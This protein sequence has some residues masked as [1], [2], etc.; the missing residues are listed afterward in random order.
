MNRTPPHI[1]TSAQN[2]VGVLFE[3]DFNQLHDV[4]V[5]EAI[6]AHS[7]IEDAPI[8]S[9]SA[10][11]YARFTALREQ[12]VSL[13]VKA[14]RAYFKLALANPSQTENDPDTWAQIQLRT[15]VF[16][17]F[18]WIHDWYIL[19]CEGES[20]SVPRV[21]SLP[22]IP[23]QT[24]SSAIPT[25]VSPLPS[26]NSWRA[27]CWLFNISLALFGIGNMKTEHVPA[28]DS[29]EKLGESHTRLLLK[30]ARR[31]FVWR[32][33][34]EIERT[35]N[36]E[37]A[38]AG[39]IRTEEVKTQKRPPNKRQG[40]ENRLKLYDCI[41]R[42]LRANPALQGID[43]CAELD[44]RH[45]PPLFDWKKSGDWREGL[46]WKEAWKDPKLRDRIRRVRQE[47]PKRD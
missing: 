8:F 20:Q 36:E 7:E 26:P 46:T 9:K 12:M 21:A 22:F 4:G 11:F 42:V 14:Y 32:L 35:R 1:F 19:A 33:I 23:G 18:A 3:H 2:A 5:T 6:C 10:R 37:I 39:A 16:A 41:R 43:F 44:K 15:A 38:A 24:V 13:F 31:I 47:A 40:Y 34:S 25:T 30:G 28:T 29:G 17:A 45:A 27:P